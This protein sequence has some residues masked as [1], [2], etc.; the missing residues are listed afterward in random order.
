MSPTAPEPATTLRPVH[1]SA[2]QGEGPPAP[3]PRDCPCRHA[4]PEHPPA[5]AQACRPCRH[6]CLAN[7]RRAD[8]RGGGQGPAVIAAL[9]ASS[10]APLW[11]EGARVYPEQGAGLLQC[12]KLATSYRDTLKS[13]A[14]FHP[15]PSITTRLQAP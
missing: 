9:C 13:P 5:Q 2:P 14:P 4:P 1:L 10:A 11:D 6:S 12:L 15:V 3:A 7:P 8:R